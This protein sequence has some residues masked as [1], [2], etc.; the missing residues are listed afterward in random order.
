MDTNELLEG[1]VSAAREAGAIMSDAG[2]IRETVAAKEGHANYVTAY[3]KRVQK[4]LFAR[5]AVLL[6][7]ARFIGEEDGADIFTEEDRHGFAFCVD[8]IDGTTNFMTGFRPSVTSIALLR[9]GF[10][11]LGV[12]Y[13]PYQDMLFTGIRGGGAFLNGK[14]IH[15]SA[16]PLSRSII[17]FG[18]A[19]YYPEYA[20]ETFALCAYYLPRCIDL[21]RIGSAAWGRGTRQPYHFITN[22]GLKIFPVFCEIGRNTANNKGKQHYSFKNDISLCAYKAAKYRRSNAPAL[23]SS[24]IC[25]Q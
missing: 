16:E 2:H 9:D 5:L 20:A 24:S 25:P 3:D 17:S 22:E 10:P 13:N 15:S 11:W 14:A 12:V 19:P 18:T 1:I 7:E 21:R 23:S 6:P 4:L 8:P